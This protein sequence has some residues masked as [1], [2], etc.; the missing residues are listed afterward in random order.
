MDESLSLLPPTFVLT[1][2]NAFHITRHA[3]YQEI[4]YNRFNPS[5]VPLKSYPN[6]MKIRS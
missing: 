3:P 6:R 1:D 4:L 2:R 5:P